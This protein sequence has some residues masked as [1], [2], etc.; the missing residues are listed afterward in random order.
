MAREVATLTRFQLNWFVIS[1]FQHFSIFDTIVLRS[2]SHIQTFCFLHCTWSVFIMES[3]GTTRNL[4]IIRVNVPKSHLSLQYNFK[5]N[6][7]L[8]EEVTVIMNLWSPLALQNIDGK[9][10]YNI[11]SISIDTSGTVIDK[12]QYFQFI[13]KWLK[14]G[15]FE[16]PKK[17]LK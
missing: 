10:R 13:L 17:N 8:R 2:I 15:K 4:K 5:K 14:T 9:Y 11:V 6:T 1:H 12:Y 7:I 3:S 16:K